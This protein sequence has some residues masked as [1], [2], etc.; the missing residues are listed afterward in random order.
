MQKY[1]LSSMRNFFLVMSVLFVSSCG[2]A[3]PPTQPPQQ[4]GQ[5]PQDTATLPLPQYIATQQ[6]LGQTMEARLANEQKT[7]MV[8][9]TAAPRPTGSPEPTL[10]LSTGWLTECASRLS[11]SDFHN[12]NV[13]TCYRSKN[14]NIY[15]TIFSGG[16]IDIPLQGQILVMTET[17]GFGHPS[18]KF[19]SPQQPLGS[20]TLQNINYP[21]ATFQANSG[22]NIVFNLDTRL[23]VTINGTPVPRDNVL[24]VVGSTTLTPAD[25][26]IKARLEAK[27]YNVL[28]KSATSSQ[29]SDA[30]GTILVIISST[31]T[32]SNVNT[33][34]RDVAVP[35]ITWDMAL[36]D[37]MLMT[38]VGVPNEQGTTEAVTTLNI[39]SDYYALTADLVGTRSIATSGVQMDYGNPNANAVVIAR[40]GGGNRA[41]IFA[42]DSCATLINNTTKAPARRVGLFMNDTTA[43]NLT[44]DGWTLVDSAIHWAMQSSPCINGA[45]ATPTPFGGSSATAT[46]VGATNTPTRTPTPAP[47]T[48]T[49]TRTPTATPSGTKTALFVVSNATSLNAGDTAVKTRLEGL[50]Y[51][52]TLKTATASATSDATGK[53]LVLISSSV[54]STDVNTKFKSVTVPVIVWEYALYDDMAMTSTTSGTDYGYNTSTSMVITNAGHPLAA[55]LSGTVSLYSAS[56]NIPFGVTTANAIS[57][58]AVSSTSTRKLEFAYD[59][60]AAMVGGFTV[61]ARRVGIFLVDTATPTTDAWTLFDAAVNW[62]TAP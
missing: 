31:V 53:T 15:T 46:I 13:S 54:A 45:T 60:N 26:A 58:G 51:S 62:S 30:N 43:A 9:P 55:G 38:N 17:L 4:A 14:A 8:L 18:R 7:A 21:L 49:A 22:S 35:V 6:I 27:G 37:D 24:F 12:F 10:A 11:P 39:V 16:L 50:G 41:V 3:T 29:T 34:F 23:W 36:Y 47:V 42:Y 44:T 57:V 56:T 5:S 52:V 2:V 25:A 19:Y 28:V 48:A 20:L 61:N 59:K 1:I 40:A 33:K 32:S